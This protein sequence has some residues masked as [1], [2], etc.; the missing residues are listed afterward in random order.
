MNKIFAWGNGEY[1]RKYKNVLSFKID[2][3]ITQN[4]KKN[5]KI[6]ETDQLIIMSISSYGIIF[7]EALKLGFREENIHCISEYIDNLTNVE[8]LRNIENLNNSKLLINRISGNI[9]INDGLTLISDQH[10]IL[11][12][13]FQNSV[14]EFNNNTLYENIEISVKENAKLTIGKNTY[15]NKN[16]IIRCYKKISIGDN[17]AI[18][19][20]INISDWGGYDVYPVTNKEKI[21]KIGNNCWIGNNVNILGGVIIGNNVVIGAGSI[22]TKNIPDNSLAVGNPAKVIRKIEKWG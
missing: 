2:E 15:I 14:L 13:T 6:D 17:C 1:Y 4:N 8:Y 12:E 21:V 11:I 7:K 20:N 3:I 22:V 5:I 16:T 18:S 9:I 19:Y 10:K